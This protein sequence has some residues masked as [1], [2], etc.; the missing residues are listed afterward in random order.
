MLGDPLA[1]LS[2]GLALLLFNFVHGLLGHSSG[3]GVGHTEHIISLNSSVHSTVAWDGLTKFGD[4]LSL[5]R[6]IDTVE[7]IDSTL[8]IL[9]L[10]GFGLSFKLVTV[11]LLS[12]LV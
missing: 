9:S 4:L 10:D 5:L 6:W 11:S 7:S 3:F 12:F 8:F 2:E 1:S